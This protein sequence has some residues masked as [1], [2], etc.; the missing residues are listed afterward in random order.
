MILR[1]SPYFPMIIFDSPIVQRRLFED[2]VFFSGTFFPF[3][4]LLLLL[5]VFV[6]I[7]YVNYVYQNKHN[8]LMNPNVSINYLQQLSIHG[9]SSLI[10]TPHL[11]YHFILFGNKLWTYD[12]I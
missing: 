1:L 7:M 5:F 10:H 12:L 6:C 9:Q 2:V 11:F 4:V 8:N 3:S